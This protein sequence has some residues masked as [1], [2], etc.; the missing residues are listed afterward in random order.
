MQVN[1]LSSVSDITVGI[2]AFNTPETLVRNTINSVQTTA[3]EATIILASNNPNPDVQVLYQHMAESLKVKFLGNLANQ[4][5]G[6]GHNKILEAVQTKYYICCNPDVIVLPECIQNLIKTAD[7]IT[8][9]GLIAPKVLNPDKSI[10]KLARRHLTILNWIIRQLGRFFKFSTFETRFDYDKPQTLEFV[11]GCFFMTRTETILG[12]AGFDERFFMYCEDADLS[13]RISRTL[14]NY[15]APEATIIHE[16]NKGWSKSTSSFV[17]H[18]KSL[19]Q[20]FLKHGVF[21]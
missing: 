7:A 17:T 13:R 21:D 14:K 19:A 15:Y 20:Y 3:P 8:D 2:L 9:L 10:Q 5:F 11:S 6:A 12:H 4:G 18:I 1:G 16:W